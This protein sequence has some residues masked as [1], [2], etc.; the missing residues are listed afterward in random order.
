MTG[1]EPANQEKLEGLFS[2]FDDAS[3]A[4]KP[5]SIQKD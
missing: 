1:I 4:D 2:S 3:W 5:G